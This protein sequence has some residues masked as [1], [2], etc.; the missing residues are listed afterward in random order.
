MK[1]TDA[2]VQTRPLYGVN[3]GGW[4]ALER[5]MT[6]SLFTAAAP[7]EYSLLLGADAN[8]QAA[9]K[10]HRDTFI[11]RKDFAWLAAQGVQAVRLPVTHG[12]FGD[13]PPC[14]RSIQYVDKAFG[15]GRQYGIK[16]LLDLHT[17]Q[18]SQNGRQESG[19]I[20]PVAWHTDPKNIVQSLYV[21]QRLAQRYGQRDE[22]LG[23]E[24]LNEPSDKIPTREL[25]KY[26]QAAYE[27]IRK[28]S[29]EH[30]WV[31]FHDA[32]KARR[33]K[34]TLSGKG[35]TNVYIDTH[36]YRAHAWLHKRTAAARHIKLMLTRVP[37]RLRHIAGGRPYIVGEWS[38]ALDQ[39]SLRKF[40]TG[41]RM[42]VRR[43][44]GAAQQAAYG[45]AAAWFYWNYK[46]EGEGPWNFR[47]CVER[48]WLSID[49]E[50]LPG[51]E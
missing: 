44:F 21:L 32:F 39:R 10:R 18:G 19:R 22:L 30:V 17:V 26:Y 20:G 3:L 48:G 8:V 15:W 28:E 36:I 27:I 35:Y 40:P 38:I 6:P 7:D 29:A 9:I 1:P 34:R 51:K 47:N 41:E 50:P 31:V 46:T 11:T 45:G 4:L 37:R 16:I 2:Q 49:R 12:V 33:F 42:E 14:T 13:A 43:T 25:N 23:I 5:W 24:L